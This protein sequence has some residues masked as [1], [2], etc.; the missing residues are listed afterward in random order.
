MQ[1]PSPLW[2]HWES[3]L[4]FTECT[5]C[6]CMLCAWCVHG[7]CV[8]PLTL[9]GHGRNGRITPPIRLVWR[10]LIA[11]DEASRDPL[12]SAK[13]LGDL[14]RTG[15]PW[16]LGDVSPELRVAGQWGQAIVEAGLQSGTWDLTP[17]VVP[18]IL[19]VVEWL[20]RAPAP[21]HVGLVWCGRRPWCAETKKAYYSTIMTLFMVCAGSVHALCMLCACSVYG[22]CM[23]CAQ[24]E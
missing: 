9:A 7:L 17:A 1:S 6:L 13:L 21:G 8:C 14:A 16:H 3:F 5:L 10:E 15:E 19:D 4:S 2:A 22:L 23:V 20:V 24:F 11:K 18:P 12:G